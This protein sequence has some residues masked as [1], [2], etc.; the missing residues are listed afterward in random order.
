MKAKLLKDRTR[1]FAVKIIQLAEQMPRTQTGDTVSVPLLRC[2]TAVGAAVR[3]AVRSRN[4]WDFA[5]RISSAEESMDEAVYWLEIAIASSLLNEDALRPV[6]EEAVALRGILVKS[7]RIAEKRLRDTRN[8]PPP[9]SSGI[10]EEDI[11]F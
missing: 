8:S 11:P 9:G 6:L 3:V 7:R 2:G 1:E 5:S 10:G 4:R